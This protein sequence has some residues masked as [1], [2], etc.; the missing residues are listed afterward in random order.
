MELST[1]NYPPQSVCPGAEGRDHSSN[2]EATRAV[3]FDVAPVLHL[4]DEKQQ[5]CHGVLRVREANG[6]APVTKLQGLVS[7]LS[8]DVGEAQK[9]FPGLL[10]VGFGG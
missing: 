4:V 3:E 10:Y 9:F 5:A 7:Y 8:A 6:F 1:C 2:F